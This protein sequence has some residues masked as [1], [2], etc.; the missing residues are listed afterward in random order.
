MAL[1]LGAAILYGAN[2]IVI[3]VTESI[4]LGLYLIDDQGS[5]LNRGQVVSVCLSDDQQGAIVKRLVTIPYGGCKEHIGRLLKVVR[6]VP[7]DQVRWTEEGVYVNGELVP[8]SR[9]LTHN[10][11]G[12][13]LPQLRQSVSLRQGQYVLLGT[14]PYSL[15]SR[16]LG[17]FDESRIEH[18]LKPLL[19]W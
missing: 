2:K 17:I 12:I 10:K 4:P 14:H 18:K 7:E 8:N 6:G 9:P 19:T 3:N 13:Q 15:D 16:Y 1:I 5:N 11:K